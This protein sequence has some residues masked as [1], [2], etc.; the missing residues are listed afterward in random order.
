MS[1]IAGIFN[2]DGRP[3]DKALLESMSEAIAHRGPDE[4]AFWLQGSVGLAHRQL[5][6]TPES[7]HE[8]QPTPRDN[9]DYVITCD[10]RVDN[11][12]EL[13]RALEVHAPVDTETSD[14]ELIL[15]AYKAWGTE[16][17]KRIAARKP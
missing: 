9:G 3:V 7:L 11:R 16:C 14:A 13:I 8:H 1:G 15:R 12:E 6:T 10:G 4:E 5:R 2:L 17:V